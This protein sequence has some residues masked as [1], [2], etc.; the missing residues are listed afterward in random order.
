[1]DTDALFIAEVYELEQRV[2]SADAYDTLM[3]AASLRKLLMDERPLVHVT[4]AA[5][6]MKLRFVANC[7]PEDSDSLRAKLAQTGAF[8]WARQDGFDPQTAR[9]GTL[10]P[11]ELSLSSL[12]ACVVVMWKGYEVTVGDL[13][14]FLAHVGGAVHAGKAR[15]AKDRALAEM[16]ASTRAG[17]VTPIIT[18]LRAIARVVLRGLVPLRDVVARDLAAHGGAASTPAT[19]I[20]GASAASVL[21]ALEQLGFAYQ[22]ARAA[23]GGAAALEAVERS[24][25]DDVALYSV[26]LARDADYVRVLTAAVH[27][28]NENSDPVA[29]EE[30]AAA[31]FTAIATLPGL[32]AQPERAAT[33]VRANI[34]QPSAAVTLG[35]T[36]FEIDAQ[37]TKPGRQYRLT[38]AAVG[39]RPRSLV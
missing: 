26:L 3:I 7:Q 10:A 11:T 14:A 32:S 9:A 34:A 27:A 15:T 37:T 6:R 4:N 5:R 20:P 29:L 25:F 22:F 13:I 2:L 21:S 19:F 17:E 1:M 38:V 24:R 36:F 33:W 12:L 23:A 18:Q 35:D 39:A 30:R 31:A 16:A 8:V 28:V